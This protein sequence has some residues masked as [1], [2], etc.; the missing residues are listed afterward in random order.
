M[1]APLACWA[2]WSVG[3]IHEESAYAVANL[4][5]TIRYASKKDPFVFFAPDRNQGFLWLSPHQIH[6]VGIS[7]R[8]KSSKLN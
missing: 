5:P 1:N 3:G 2:T 8:K 6:I 7:F 4:V